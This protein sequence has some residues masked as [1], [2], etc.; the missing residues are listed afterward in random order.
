MGDADKEGEG[1][2]PLSQPSPGSASTSPPHGH[3]AE[4]APT[5]SSLMSPPRKH[6]EALQ[7]QPSP[8]PN[9]ASTVSSPRHAAHDHDAEP[10]PTTSSLVSSPREHREALQS[11]PSPS[12]N[13][14]STVSSPRHAAHDHDAEP[15][16]TALLRP[17]FMSPITTSGGKKKQAASRSPKVSGEKEN[18]GG[19]RATAESSYPVPLFTPRYSS[20]CY[21]VPDETPQ[22][23]VPESYYSRHIPTTGKLTAGGWLEGGRDTTDRLMHAR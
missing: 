10:A 9:M 8:S 5:A 2:A 12:S 14:A 1:L 3:D 22:Y 6:R 23:A 7:S 17:S 20:G 16:P 4:P 15:T 21:P 18:E 13:L 19:G 11:Q